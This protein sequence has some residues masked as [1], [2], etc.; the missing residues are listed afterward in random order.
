MPGCRQ[1]L[2]L[3]KP[4]KSKYNHVYEN[5]LGVLSLSRIEQTAQ[6]FSASGFDDKE[7]KSFLLPA[8]RFPWRLATYELRYSGD[9]L[10]LDFQKNGQ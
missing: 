6:I 1:K 10:F 4:S 2:T 5:S 9:D 3:S 7:G 8:W